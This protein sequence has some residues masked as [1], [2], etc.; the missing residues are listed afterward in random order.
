MVF[1]QSLDIRTSLVLTVLVGALFA[2]AMAAFTWRHR[3]F[4]GMAWL[5]ASDGL[6]VVALIASPSA[7]GGH[8]LITL[9]LIAVLVLLVLG[10]VGVL[11]AVVRRQADALAHQARTD[12][13]T[14]RLNRRALM[15]QGSLEFER[16][17]RQG[18]PLS[19]I[20]VDVDYFK[21]INDGYGHK[22]GDVVLVRLS[23]LLAEHTR[24]FDLCARFGGEEF[25][26]LLPGT[27][28]STAALVAEKLRAELAAEAWP[29][30]DGRRTTASFG[31]AAYA[32]HDSLQELIAAADRALY[33]AKHG[34]RNRVESVAI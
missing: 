31:V 11:L 6:L 16:S 22:V 2:L 30:L 34:G 21:A 8:A 19:A 5:A 33:A 20:M 3:E 23:R 4:R 24:R 15:E 18:L 17:R 9:V 26:I 7:G 29:E 10:N 25:L 28:L 32:G 1:L 27:P 14:G 13:L 12:P